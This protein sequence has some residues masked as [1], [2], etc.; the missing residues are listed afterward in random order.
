MGQFVDLTGMTF[1]RLY[2]LEKTDK[3]L[4]GYTVYKC[5]CECGN[6]TEVTAMNLKL[7]K[8]RSCGCLY[9]EDLTG[10]TFERLKVLRRAET[11]D[12]STI[13]WVC[14]CKCGNI[15]EVDGAYLRNGD[16]KS[17]GC[18]KTEKSSQ[19][20]KAMHVEDTEPHKLIH[21]AEGKVYKNNKSGCAGVRQTKSGKYEAT[22]TF[23]KKLY[24]LGTFKDFEDAVKARRAAE[25]TLFK[26]IIE[27]YKKE[28]HK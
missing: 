18:L 15:V 25:D 20:M 14:E 6:I 28:K 17:C 9:S 7:G 2:V 26:P 8:T 23:K 1:D 16:V 21:I 19:R 22:I 3:R 4:H 5:Q 24:R 27:K 10:K 12:R 13:K 11:K